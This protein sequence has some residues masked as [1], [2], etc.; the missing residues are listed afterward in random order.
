LTKA[1]DD[2]ATASGGGLGTD[3][4]LSAARSL[5]RLRPRLFRGLGCKP[6]ANRPIKNREAAQRLI[7]SYGFALSAPAASL[8]AGPA[9]NAG[10]ARGDAGPDARAKGALPTLRR[11]HADLL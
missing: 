11:A 6:R 9:G 8:A 3:P 2:G 5:H 7:A 1:G 10:Q 4:S